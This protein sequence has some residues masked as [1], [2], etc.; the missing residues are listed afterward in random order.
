M[1]KM[2][3]RTNL[4]DQLNGLD[5]MVREANALAKNALESIEGPKEEKLE[6][7]PPVIPGIKGLVESLRREISLSLSLIIQINE[8]L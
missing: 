3:A 2:E 4:R 1:P 6:P 5:T 7:G 8:L